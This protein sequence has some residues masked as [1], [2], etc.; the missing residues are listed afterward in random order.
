M[1]TILRCH[2]NIALNCTNTPLLLDNSEI[3]EDLHF[4]MQFEMS[5]CS[6]RFGR[7]GSLSKQLTPPRAKNRTNLQHR[8]P[9]SRKW[10]VSMEY[11]K[12]PGYILHLNP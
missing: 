11:T 10:Q 3:D 4:A 9:L 5:L 6:S 8:T 12:H 7:L 1:H 2:L